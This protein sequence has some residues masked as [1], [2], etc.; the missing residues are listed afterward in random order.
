ME[1]GTISP[2]QNH[3]WYQAVK[4]LFNLGFNMGVF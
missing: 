2:G 1:G 4:G 3:F